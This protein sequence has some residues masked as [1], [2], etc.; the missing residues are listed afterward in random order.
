MSSH[1]DINRWRGIQFK[2]LAAPKS[3]NS[4]VRIRDRIRGWTTLVQ[5][6][7]HGSPPAESSTGPA[8]GAI[9]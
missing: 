2:A 8:I 3:E 4:F 5:R 9:A 7:Y 6:T 1:A